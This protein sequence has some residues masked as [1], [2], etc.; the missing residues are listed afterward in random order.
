MDTI[1]IVNFLRKL[2]KDK[3]LTQE[4]LAEQLNVSRRTISRWETGVSQN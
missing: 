1:K 4:Q 2:R 3:Q